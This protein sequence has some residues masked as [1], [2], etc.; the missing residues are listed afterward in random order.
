M[1][2]ISL[3]Q[4]VKNKY[5]SNADAIQTENGKIN[6]SFDKMVKK[7]MKSILKWAGGKAQLLPQLIPHF[8]KKF[9]RYFE[10]FLGAGAIY[11]ALDPKCPAIINDANPELFELYS[12]L[13]DHP[14][15]LMRLLDKHAK[16][17]S[18]N[19]YYDLRASSPRT[20]I[21]RAARFIFLNKTGFNG[22]YRLNSK[23]Q[24]NVPWGKLKNPQIFDKNNLIKLKSLMN[25]PEWPEAVSSFQIVDSNSEEEKMDRAEGI[26]DI[27]VQEDLLSKKFL[28]FDQW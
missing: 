15:E 8:P 11:F 7:T 21:S 27:I 10:P 13:R 14:T 4:Y 24:F 28:L 5:G 18:E 22:L 12:V 9:N 17:Y 6:L 20:P 1:N 16:K 19:F 25:S 3:Q 2:L 26:V 23:G